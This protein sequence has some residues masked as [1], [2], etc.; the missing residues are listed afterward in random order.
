MEN[1]K[2]TFPTIGELVR[3]IFN[4]TGLLAQ[5]DRSNSFL[6]ESNKKKLQ[7]KLKRLADESSKIDGKLDEL[8][9]SLKHLLEK[10][11]GEE[12]I[13]CMVLEAVEVLL[14]TY[15]GVLGDDGTY[16]DKTNSTRW[17]IKQYVLD[18]VLLSFYKNY[19]RLNVPASKLS[20]PDLR[21]WALPNTE[22]QKISWP[23]RNA[24]QLIYDSLSISQ[25]SFHYPDKSLED[26]RASQN[27]ENAQHWSTTD[28][29][30]TISS[31]FDNLEY[32]LTLLDS[33][34]NDSAR[35]IVSASEKQRLKLI[36][37]IGRVSAYCFRE[38]ERNFGR[39][40]LI[41]CLK[42]VQGQSSRLS[43]INLRLE[44]HLKTVEKSIGSMSEVDVNQLYF[45]EISEYWEQFAIS[46]EHG[47]RLLQGYINDESFSNLTELEKSKLVIAHV[48]TF[49]GHGVLT[50]LGMTPSVK[51]M[52]SEFPELFYE[53]LKLKKSPTSLGD[54]DNY[55]NRLRKA[56]LDDV[57]SWLVNWGYANYFYT[58]KSFDKSYGY[59]EKAFNQAKYSAGRNQYLL[60]NQYIESC[61]KN[62]KYKEMKKAVAWAQYL[63]IKIRWLRGWDD[64]ESEGNLKGLY[65]LM[66]NHNMQ[67]A[68]L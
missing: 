68:Q 62:G 46:T 13:V 17:F 21:I 39:E 55:H 59:Y 1:N 22:G 57:L 8:L 54:I 5:K 44:K 50:L 34:S 20:L 16:L 63:G 66:G 31:L 38:L 32:S 36:L 45:Y 49:A 53:G 26:Y 40:F 15:K 4:I 58:H 24:W 25:S 29:I 12:R 6:S 14:A 52:P 3:E 10:A 11:F 19:L 47:S 2:A 56:G 43:R 35:R 48:G 23:L 41:E 28:Q 33:T 18:R 37:F 42:H 60:V 30:P 51:G 67:Y 7:T 61:A 64:P 9:D 65:N 27:L